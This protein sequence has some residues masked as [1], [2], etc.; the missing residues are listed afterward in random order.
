[1]L[2]TFVRLSASDIEKRPRIVLAG[3]AVGLCRLSRHL[4]AGME[5]LDITKGLYA[6]WK[7]H[8]P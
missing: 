5:E 4:D 3:Q 6:S 1:M 8:L 2:F 7:C